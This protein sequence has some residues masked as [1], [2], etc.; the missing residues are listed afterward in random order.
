MK[1]VRKERERKNNVGKIKEKGQMAELARKTFSYSPCFL[2]QQTIVIVLIELQPTIQLSIYSHKDE[3][4]VDEERKV[5][6]I[7][8]HI[9]ETAIHRCIFRM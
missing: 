7:V 4:S 1:E 3:Y 8:I 5:M 9:E 2:C 6:Y